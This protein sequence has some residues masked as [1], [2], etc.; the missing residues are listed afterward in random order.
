MAKKPQPQRV[1]PEIARQA[2]AAAAGDRH[3]VYTHYIVLSFRQTGSLAPGCDARDLLAWL[4]EHEQDQ[5]YTASSK[6]GA[7]RGT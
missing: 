2:I 4:D 3:T 5:P 7:G 6:P 1:S